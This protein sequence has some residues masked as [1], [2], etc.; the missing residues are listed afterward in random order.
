MET[1]TD[2]TRPRA[3]PVLLVDD[4]EDVREIFKIWLEME[5]FPVRA[6]GSAKEGLT[7][8]EEGLLPSVVFVDY[9]MPEM[10]G[11]EFISALRARRLLMDIPIYMFSAH[12]S[13]GPVEGA[14]GWI[15][16]PLNLEHVLTVIRDTTL[17]SLNI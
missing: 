8:I 13:L 17:G 4:S 9:S 11:P 2:Q 14:R 10:N 6:V 16:K 15:R 12:S 7:C 3:G 1:I 5:G